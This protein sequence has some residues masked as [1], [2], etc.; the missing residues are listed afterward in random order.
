MLEHKIWR[1]IITGRELKRAG[2]HRIVMYFVRHAKNL[3]FTLGPNSQDGARGLST[4]EEPR[5]FMRTAGPWAT[6]WSYRVITSGRDAQRSACFTSDSD[7]HWS[8]RTTALGNGALGRVEDSW[9]LQ[10]TPWFRKEQLRGECLGAGG[11]RRNASKVREPELDHSRGAGGSAKSPG[12]PIRRRWWAKVS[13]VLEI[14]S[15][16]WRNWKS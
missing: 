1:G 12:V 14:C 2:W 16:F 3:G 6:P 7:T 13:G 8:L 10:W 15:P 4:L 9:R 11:S 5:M